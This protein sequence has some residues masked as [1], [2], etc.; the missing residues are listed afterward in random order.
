M[1]RLA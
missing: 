1:Y